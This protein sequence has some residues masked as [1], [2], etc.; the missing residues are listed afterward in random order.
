YAIPLSGQTSFLLYSFPGLSQNTRFMILIDRIS[1]YQE[2]F[3]RLIYPSHCGVCHAFLEIE[4]KGIC[5]SCH[6]QLTHLAY[7]PEQMESDE[8][9]P[10]LDDL[11]SIYPYAS[12]FK[13]IMTAVKFFKKRWLMNVFQG[14]VTAWALRIKSEFYW[15][16]IIPVPMD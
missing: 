3:L 7:A 5:R 4:E 10:F 6:A 14:D 12:P 1:H 15:D 8:T 2:A 16:G 13:E 11:W 9:H